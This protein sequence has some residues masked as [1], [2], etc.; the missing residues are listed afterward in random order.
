MQDN[1][2]F[3]SNIIGVLVFGDRLSRKAHDL[4]KCRGMSLLLFPFGFFVQSGQKGCNHGSDDHNGGSY[5]FAY[6]C[7]ILS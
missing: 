1:E 6:A 5:L 2:K 7:Y 4:G 3:F